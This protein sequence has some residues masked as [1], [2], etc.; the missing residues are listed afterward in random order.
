MAIAEDTGDATAHAMLALCLCERKEYKGATEEARQ[1]IHA[2]PDEAVGFYAMATIMHNRNRLKNAYSAITEAI[3]IEP[4]N[5]DFFG[6]LAMIEF[7]RSRWAECLNAAEQGLEFEPEDV[8]CTNL[9]AMALVK[10]GRRDEAESTIDTALASEPDNA[11]TH[12]NLGWTL[13]HSGDPRKAMEHFREALRLEPGLEWARLGIIE[14][15]KARNPIYRWMLAWFLWVGRLSPRIQIALILGLVFG[16]S[17]LQSICDAIPILAPLKTPIAVVYILFVWMTWVASTLFNLVLCLD[18]FGRLV[19]STTEKVGAGLTGACI[20]SM[21][22]VGVYGQ[23][24]DVKFAYYYWMTGLL[25]L[26]LAIP[27][28]T[29][30]NLEAGRR[31]MMAVYSVGLLIV[32]L[33]ALSKLGD[34]SSA[35]GKLPEKLKELNDPLLLQVFRQKFRAYIQWAVYG[36]NGVAISTW[37]GFGMNFVPSRE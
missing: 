7:G 9:R 1:A 21:F 5:A 28:T 35:F 32:I 6:M 12:A 29:C 22:A 8:D 4:W 14:A 25:F 11:V 36:L 26:G 24:L 10:L 15:M 30:L 19:L 17:I 33:I 16:Q 27:V 23:L 3:R 37:L 13:L 20:A 31:I 18:R 34:A 2:A